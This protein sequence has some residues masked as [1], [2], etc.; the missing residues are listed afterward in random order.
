MLVSYFQDLAEE[1]RDHKPDLDDVIVVGHD[2]MKHSTGIALVS[3]NLALDLRFER[4]AQKTII[5][6][7]CLK[8][9]ER[10]GL[11]R[12]SSPCNELYKELVVDVYA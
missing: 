1:I 3:N 10:L 11:S 5:V 6:L 4:Q 12:V 9:C 2:L 7:A 8:C